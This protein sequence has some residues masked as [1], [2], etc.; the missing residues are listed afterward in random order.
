[1][2]GLTKTYTGDLTQAIAG[3][4]WGE[5]KDRLDGDGEGKPSKKV[6][7]AAR[8]LKKDDPD[9]TKVQDKSL[10]ETV[11]KI[12]GPIDAKLIATERKADNISGKVSAVTASLVDTQNLIINQNQILEDKFD[13]ILQLLNKGEEDKEKREE[14][15]KFSQL[16]LFDDLRE[17]LDK[18]SAISKGQGRRKNNPL[19]DFIFSRLDNIGRE[20]ALKTLKKAWKSKALK[21]VRVPIRMLERRASQEITKTL[22]E[23]GVRKKTSGMLLEKLLKKGGARMIPV[24]S[25][26]MAADD[27]DRYRKQGDF[28]GMGLAFIDMVASG[29]EGSYATGVGAPIGAAASVVA[30]IAGWGL[31]AYELFQIFALGKDPYSTSGFTGWERGNVNLTPKATTNMTNSISE[32]LGITKAVMDSS[33]F[34]SEYNTLTSEAGLGS[35]SPSTAN[36]V[37]DIGGTGGSSSSV[38]S[39][40]EMASERSLDLKEKKKEPECPD[41]MKWDQEANKCMPMDPNK[42]EGIKRNIGGLVD[43]ATFGLTDFD[44][45]GDLFKKGEKTDEHDDRN[46]FQKTGDF[47]DPRNWFNKWGR[48]NKKGEG[49]PDTKPNTQRPIVGRVGNTGNSTGPHVHIQRFPPPTSYEKDHITKDHPVIDHIFVGGKPLSDWDFTSP[50]SPDRWGRPHYGPDFGGLGINNQPITF[51][52]QITFNPETLYQRSS[53]GEGNNILFEYNG[54]QF[55]IFHLNSGPEGDLA[56][57]KRKD[58][59]LSA[60]KLSSP[61]DS[62]SLS[63]RSS[64]VSRKSEDREVDRKQIIRNSATLIV[65]N[66]I[67]EESTQ[68]SIPINKSSSIDFINAYNLAKHTV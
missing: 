16:E 10:R 44:Q 68:R 32:I 24:V 48:G 34:G 5:I 53:G 61:I 60:D 49:G 28:L 19:V 17:D 35:F 59:D 63:R 40:T 56:A 39:I 58:G 64:I 37:S 29:V 23:K 20:W 27:V 31:T 2:A 52:D 15:A 57:P 51:S 66:I 46:I 30:N 50:A 47:L 6:R 62:S 12:F 3:K 22:V 11:L 13:T 8:E 18:S 67:V 41:G 36:V 55:T 42:P 38:N 7:Q 43:F 45:Q 65:N 14:D 54:E 33:G 4:L 25:S 21:R 1:M 9:A 26:V